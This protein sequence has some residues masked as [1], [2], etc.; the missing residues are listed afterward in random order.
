MIDEA[1]V[2]MGKAVMGLLPDVRGE[3]VIQRRDFSSAT[4]TERDF[5][6][7]G[8]LVEH[9]IDDVNKCLVAIEEPMPP[10]SRYPSSQPSH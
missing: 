8:V 6:P 4:A 9:R 1:R 5:Q 7:L 3:Q 10:V 2:L